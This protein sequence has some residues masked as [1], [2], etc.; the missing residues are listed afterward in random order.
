MQISDIIWLRQF[1][2]KLE[3]KHGVSQWEVNEVVAHRFVGL[4]VVKLKGKMY[5]KHWG[6][7]WMEGT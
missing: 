1:V 5:M 4:P 2:E 7:Q 3:T 6:R